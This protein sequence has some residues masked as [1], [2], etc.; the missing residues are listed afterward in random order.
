MLTGKTRVFKVGL[1]SQVG[2]TSGPVEGL[3]CDK[4]K[5]YDTTVAS[6]F[7]ER[8]LGCQLKE[9][10]ELTTKRFLEATERF[11]HDDVQEPEKKARYQVAL[12]AELGS[13]RTTV[14]PQTFANN[15]LEA[16]DRASFIDKVAEAGVSQPSFSKDNTLVAS[17]LR[18]IQWSFSSGVA[19]LA[20]PDNVGREIQLEDLDDGRTRLEVTDP[21]SAAYR[22][23]GGPARS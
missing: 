18:R 2:G 10:P 1:F 23:S 21:T 7:L 22:P 20:S 3:V 14:S 11:I 6:F 12:A 4:Q 17:H 13:T 8:F 15:N 9:L 19:V 5:G 16:D